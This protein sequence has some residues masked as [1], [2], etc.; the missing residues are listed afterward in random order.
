MKP[1]MAGLKRFIPKP[2]KHSR[3]M[4]MAKTVPITVKYHGMSG[5]KVRANSRAVTRPDGSCKARFKLRPRKKA[6]KSWQITAVTAARA[7]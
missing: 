6:A 2:P 4:I 3:T 5:G 7:N 1:D